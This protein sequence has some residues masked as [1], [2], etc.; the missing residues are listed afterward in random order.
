MNYCYSVHPGERLEEAEVDVII[1]GMEDKK[2]MIQ[3]DGKNKHYFLPF[4]LISLIL[5]IIS[6]C[7]PMYYSDTSVVH[8]YP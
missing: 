3:I 5:M 2:G 6:Q 1:K 4:L 8:L 7:L